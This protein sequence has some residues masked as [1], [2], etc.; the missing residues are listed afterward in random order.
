MNADKKMKLNNH[1]NHV[2]PVKKKKYLTAELA[3]NAEKKG[4]KN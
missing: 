4:I 1:V 2:N 3:E